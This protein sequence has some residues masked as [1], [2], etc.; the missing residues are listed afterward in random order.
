MMQNERWERYLLDLIRKLSGEDS[1]D[2]WDALVASLAA[3][4]ESDLRVC[5]TSSRLGRRILRDEEKRPL[6]ASSIG[7]IVELQDIGFPASLIERIVE[8]TQEAESSSVFPS[9]L[10]EVVAYVLQTEYQD[11]TRGRN[12]V[13]D[14]MTGPAT[15][16]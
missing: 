8:Q 14:S 9:E 15:V 5:E 1:P 10:L 2:Q 11:V 13:V 6:S 7:L 4:P 3:L 16:H 12:V